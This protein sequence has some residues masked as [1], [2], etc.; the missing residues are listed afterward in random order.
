MR[1]LRDLSGFENGPPQPTYKHKLLAMIDE[2]PALGKLE[3]LQQSL[4][5]TP[6]AAPTLPTWT[7]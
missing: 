4:T 6:N 1:S 3:I 2:F 7:L 5:V